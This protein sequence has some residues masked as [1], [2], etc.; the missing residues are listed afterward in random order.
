MREGVVE[1]MRH[2]HGDDDNAR[3]QMVWTES[4]GPPVTAPTRKGFG[5]RLIQRAL[6]MEL[7]GEV[8]V[9]YQPTGICVQSMPQYRRGI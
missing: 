2:V 6:A 5:T 3:L 8:T 9:L 4:G 7:A 1:I